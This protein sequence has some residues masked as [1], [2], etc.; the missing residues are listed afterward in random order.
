MLLP[1]HNHVFSQLSFYHLSTEQLQVG[2][3]AL[4]GINCLLASF[5]GRRTAVEY[6]GQVNMLALISI[7]LLTTLMFF[8]SFFSI[9]EWIIISGLALIT[10]FI[11][12]EYYRRMKYAGIFTRHK[13]IILINIICLS[14]FL[15]YVFHWNIIKQIISSVIRFHQHWLTRLLILK[16]AGY[17][18]KHLSPLLLYLYL[19]Y[20]KKE[21]VGSW[22]FW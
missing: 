17:W 12:K 19:Y 18:T 22:C 4:V 7:L 8:T 14:I 15:G 11:I 1:L 6:L 9:P 3:F 16:L 21:N 13:S 20:G 5:L 2:H 10:G